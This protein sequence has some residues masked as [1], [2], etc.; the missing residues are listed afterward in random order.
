MKIIDLSQE[1]FT[2]MSVFPG[3]PEVRIE[4]VLTIEDGGW[5]V[6]RLEINSHD[7]THV[8]LPAHVVADGKIVNDFRIEAFMGDCEIYIKG[9]VMN[10]NVG[11]IF[12][13]QNIDK[14]ITEQIKLQKPKFVGLSEDFEFDLEIEKD[15]LLNGIVSY[16]KLANLKSLPNNFKFYGVPLKIRNGEGSPVRAFAVVE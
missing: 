16:E 7:G 1:L 11:V 13:D 15:L 3:D 2:G 6:R 9:M 10:E 12:R 4:P 14:E 5:L 8:N